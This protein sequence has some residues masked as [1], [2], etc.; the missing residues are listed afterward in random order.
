MT[1]ILTSP[2]SLSIIADPSFVVGHDLSN[3]G[4]EQQFGFLF[5]FKA[6]LAFGVF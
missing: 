4:F 2:A 1:K 3:R 6:K 5:G